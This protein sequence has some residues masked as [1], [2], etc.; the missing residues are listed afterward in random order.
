MAYDRGD[1]H[2]KWRIER[3]AAQIRAS[4]GLDQLEVLS[5]DLLCD[6]VPAHVFVPSDFEAPELEVR[7]RRVP[8]DG[9]SF[10]F[11]GDPTLMVLLNPVRPRARQTASLM[12]ELSHHLLGHQPS[13]IWH[14]ES[15]GL[16]RRT[17]NRGQ[18]DEAYDLGAA[19]LLPKER[20]QME[21]G[22]QRVASDVA[23]EH[24]CSAELVEYRIK[25]MRLWGKYSKYVA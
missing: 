25:R 2:D 11:P 20:I 16:L 24:G 23:T 4:V 19:L 17:F 21:V 15:T 8:W 14:D 6:A 7:L 12:E 1:Y 18:E 5:P 13:M 3:M 10:S 9:F 22:R